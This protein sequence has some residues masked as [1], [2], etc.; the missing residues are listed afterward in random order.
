[1]VK[2]SERPI[3]IDPALKEIKHSKLK[4]TQLQIVLINTIICI[5]VDTDVVIIIA[6]GV[7]GL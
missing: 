3:R 7:N 1:M 4:M 5:G 2:T 6:L